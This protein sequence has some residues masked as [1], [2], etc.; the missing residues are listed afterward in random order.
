[1]FVEDVK[2]RIQKRVAI[3]ASMI[4]MYSGLK[5]NAYLSGLNIPYR[6]IDKLSIHPSKIAQKI[7]QKLYLS[8]PQNSD[9]LVTI[10]TT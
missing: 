10:H 5:C 3:Q 9:S 8:V 1:M 2:R 6:V 4:C 7:K